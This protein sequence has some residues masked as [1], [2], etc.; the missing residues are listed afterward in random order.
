M[1]EKQSLYRKSLI[2]HLY[3]SGKL[4]CA[5]LSVL[6]DKSLPHTARALNDLLEEGVIVESGL[7]TSTGGRRPQVY[8]MKADFM[9][10]V[11]VAMDQFITHISIL[12][13]AN[14]VVGNIE[15]VEL[16]LLT[17]PQAIKELAQYLVLY[18]Q[19]EGIPKEKIAGIGIGMPG[20]VD[21]LKGV[22]YSFFNGNGSNIINYV[23]G[24]QGRRL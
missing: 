6:T 12:D 2:K 17:N 15:R 9:Y 16:N 3:F 20:F 24:V 21:G 4:S 18:I 23:E 7:A 22:N 19:K 11:S 1:S 14:Q 5:E 13:M 10:V 8:S